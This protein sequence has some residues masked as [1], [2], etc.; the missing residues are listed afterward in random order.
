[1]Y[2]K[3]YRKCKDFSFLA[4]YSTLSSAWL[5]FPVYG[6][7]RQKTEKSAWLRMTIIDK[8][9]VSLKCL[10]QMLVK[11][12]L[13]GTVEVELV[14]FIIESVS[15]IFFYHVF[16]F[17]PS[18]LQGFYHLVRFGFVDARVVC[19]LGDE[20]RSFDLVYMEYWRVFFH[21]FFVGWG[22]PTISCIM[23][24][25]GFQYGGIVFMNESRLD[26]PT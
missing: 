7:K 12:F 21:H 6:P 26:T 25:N 20:Q 22:S 9:S 23:S 18:F 2:R 17:H 19:P 15:F 24:S 3:I 13:H 8:L 11:E 1:M 14:L 16:H 5:G 10:F 4:Q